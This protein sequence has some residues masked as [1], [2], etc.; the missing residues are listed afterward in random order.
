V[1][2]RPFVSI[3][4][5]TYNRAYCLDRSIS[6]VLSQSFRDLELIIVDD[7]STDGTAE[8][9]R[10]YTDDRIRVVVHRSNRGVAA[11]K[12]TGLDNARGD[13]IGILDSDDE[14]LPGALER[15]VDRIRSIS[16]DEKLGTIIGNTMR[17]DGTLTGLGVTEDGFIPCEDL[18]SGRV[19]GEFTGLVSRAVLGASRLDEKLLSFEST[20]WLELYKRSSTYY[21][22]FPAR[23]YHVGNPD[24]LSSF[25]ITAARSAHMVYGYSVM[26]QKHGLDFIKHCPARY[27][28]YL[29]RKALFQ[30]LGHRNGYALRDMILALRW[31]GHDLK[32]W[33]LFL[34]ACLAPLPVTIRVAELLYKRSHEPGRGR[35][36][37]I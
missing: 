11:A 20:L 4:I 33:F 32:E 31:S 34:L 12:N 6:S 2:A 22:H 7:G 19:R 27:G 16:P 23:I 29:R 24:Q 36:S 3:V 28:Y 14:Y 26:L 18:L 5:P 17:Q 10:G 37:R 21:M 30:K 8:M 15:L 1:E 25:T 13:W 9:L 35:Q